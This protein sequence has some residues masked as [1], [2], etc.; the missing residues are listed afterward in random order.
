LASQLV[1]WLDGTHDRAAL[2]R[3]LAEQGAL[4]GKQSGTDVVTQVLG[5][6]AGR[7]LLESEGEAS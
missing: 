4:T 2:A 3:L 7:A 1:S 6:L 5:A